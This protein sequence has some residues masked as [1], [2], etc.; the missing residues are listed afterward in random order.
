MT[1]Q[2]W[3][4]IANTS[5]VLDEVGSMIQLGSSDD[6]GDC[7]QVWKQADKSMNDQ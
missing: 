5:I 3:K 1:P 7:E 2:W 6:T 4:K